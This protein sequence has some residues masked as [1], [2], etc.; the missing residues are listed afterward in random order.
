MR[1]FEDT[2]AESGDM[3]A[4]RDE[5]FDA[6]AEMTHASSDVAQSNADAGN[7][8]ITEFNENLQ[9]TPD[10]ATLSEAAEDMV[11][12]S[13]AFLADVKGLLTDRDC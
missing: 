4:A 1:A 12:A 13:G 10:D 2:E 8:P 5:L 11:D 7:N 3:A 9:E 6:M